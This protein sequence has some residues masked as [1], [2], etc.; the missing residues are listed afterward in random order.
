MLNVKMAIPIHIRKLP[1]YKGCRTMEY[2]P[3][4]FSDSATCPLLV[5]LPEVPFGVVAIE[6]ALIKK[7]ERLVM[8]AIMVSISRSVWCIS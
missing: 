1:R 8:M 5:F 2:M 3:E 4:W 6:T 7:P